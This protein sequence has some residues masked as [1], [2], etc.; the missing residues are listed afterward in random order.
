VSPSADFKPSGS[1]V[2]ED[3]HKI[4]GIPAVVKMLLDENLLNGDCVTVTG[5][6]LK[7]NVKDLPGLPQ[8]Q[9]SCGPFRIR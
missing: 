3:L 5:K 6:T 8:G 1:Y 7:E 9:P 4:G 2:M